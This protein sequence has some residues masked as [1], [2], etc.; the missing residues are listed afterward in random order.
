VTERRDGLEVSWQLHQTHQRAVCVTPGCYTFIVK[1]NGLN[2][3][4]ACQLDRKIA[5]PRMG[6][7]RKTERQSRVAAVPDSCQQ[8]GCLSPVETWCPLCEHFL[9]VD[10]DA[11]TPG[12]HHDCLKGPAE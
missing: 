4:L 7:P 5:Q 2:L 3:C 9:C 1:P 10:H 8:A 6:R 11:L 12:R